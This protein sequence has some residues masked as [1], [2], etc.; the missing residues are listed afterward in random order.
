MYAYAYVSVS[1]VCPCLPNKRNLLFPEDRVNISSFRKFTPFS[2]KAL[3]YHFPSKETHYSCTPNLIIPCRKAGFLFFGG[4]WNGEGK[5]GNPF[6][7]SCPENPL[8][9]GKPDGLQSMGLQ[10]VGHKWVTKHSTAQHSTELFLPILSWC[11][12][13][14]PRRYE[15]DFFHLIYFSVS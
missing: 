9:W 1:C 12:M 7:Y 2:Y 15:L 14:L 13:L 8:G 6:Q 3:F 5:D 10:R 4:G 11:L